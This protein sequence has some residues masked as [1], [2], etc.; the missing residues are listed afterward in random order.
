MQ[1]YKDMCRR[2][3]SSR[4]RLVMEVAKCDRVIAEVAWTKV[5]T[6]PGHTGLEAMILWA[7]QQHQKLT[8]LQQRCRQDLQKPPQGPPDDPPAPDTTPANG[9]TSHNRATGDSS[10]KSKQAAPESAPPQPYCHPNATQTWEQTV[11]TFLSDEGITVDHKLDMQDSI[12]PSTVDADEAASI[13]A[14]CLPL[15]LGLLIHQAAAEMQSPVGMMSTNLVMMGYPPQQVDWRCATAAEIAGPCSRV[16]P[17]A[18]GVYFGT[19]SQT[20]NRKSTPRL[21]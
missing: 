13:M 9:E 20:P 2:A 15:G 16:T 6:V 10:G 7:A 8:K 18:S 14:R 17:V 12:T 21:A 5:G 11:K 19:G 1:L 4:I 3:K